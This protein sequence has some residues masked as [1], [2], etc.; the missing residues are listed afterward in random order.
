MARKEGRTHDE[1][2]RTVIAFIPFPLLK[3][4]ATGG[5]PDQSSRRGGLVKVLPI[6]SLAALVA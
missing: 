5:V 3:R 4:L 2:W 1:H 6:N